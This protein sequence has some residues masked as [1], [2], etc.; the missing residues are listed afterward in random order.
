MGECVRAIERK[1]IIELSYAA[2]TN[3]GT[4]VIN[5]TGFTPISVIDVWI[6]EN[7]AA[8]PSNAATRG[9]QLATVR[10]PQVQQ[11][12]AQSGST[13]T[14][15]NLPASYTPTAAALVGLSLLCLSG[16]NAGT[17]QAIS[18]NTSS[19]ITTAAFTSTPAVGDQYLVAGVIVDVRNN[20]ASAVTAGDYGLVYTTYNNAR[21]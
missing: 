21:G 15:F 6:Q 9:Q 19:T 5:D 3:G 18:A 17:S 11:F 4:V 13:T 2:T 10:V 12:G 7:S 20:S 16:A 14:V 8:G 1:L